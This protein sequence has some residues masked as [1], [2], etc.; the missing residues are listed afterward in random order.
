[1]VKRSTPSPTEFKLLALLFT[2]RSGRETAKLYEQRHGAKISYGT[3]YTT[4]SRMVD[5]GWVK[6][7]E[8]QG[9]DRRLR[10]FRITGTGIRV[11]DQTATEYGRLATLPEAGSC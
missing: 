11:R 4:L 6:S 8:S 2:E 9:E 10:M 3:L 7:R 5:E 1:M